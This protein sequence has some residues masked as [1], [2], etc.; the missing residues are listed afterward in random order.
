MRADAG[1]KRAPKSYG[2]NDPQGGEINKGWI[3]LQDAI[4]LFSRHQDYADVSEEQRGSYLREY[5]A[6]QEYMNEASA[7]LNGLND[8]EAVRRQYGMFIAK[9]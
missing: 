7:S 3:P 6:L 4:D 2:G 8:G 1:W 9:K 5:T